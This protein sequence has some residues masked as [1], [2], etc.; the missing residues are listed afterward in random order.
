MLEGYILANFFQN[1]LFINF[2][3]KQNQKNGFE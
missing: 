1:L 2:N 3:I